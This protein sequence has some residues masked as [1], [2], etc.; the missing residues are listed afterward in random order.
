M[1]GGCKGRLQFYQA[2]QQETASPNPRQFKEVS[3]ANFHV[4]PPPF[5]VLVIYDRDY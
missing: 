3:S 2:M 4:L 1:L 5:N